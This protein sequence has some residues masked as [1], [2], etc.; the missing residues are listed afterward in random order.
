MNFIF[1]KNRRNGNLGVVD[2]FFVDRGLGITVFIKYENI[3]QVEAPV[4]YE[5][6]WNV[7][8]DYLHPAHEETGFR[9]PFQTKDEANALHV[10]ILENWKAFHRNHTSLEEK[11]NRF[12]SHID[13]L[14]GGEEYENA[15]ERFHS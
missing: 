5:E 4:L 10:K 1:G 12:I 2:G 6:M 13:V 3:Y 7:I 14:P 15:K 9:F 11:I 8:V